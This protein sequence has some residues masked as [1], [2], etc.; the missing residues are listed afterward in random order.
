VHCGPAR[1]PQCMQRAPSS[2]HARRNPHPTKN[3]RDEP[4]EHDQRPRGVHALRRRRQQR[5]RDGARR[6]GGR[7]RGRVQ[8]VSAARVTPH[9]HRSPLCRSDSGVAPHSRPYRS[10]LCRSDSGVA[11]QRRSQVHHEGRA[12]ERAD[13]PLSGLPRGARLPH[14]HRIP[15]QRRPGGDH[16][17]HWRV[18][19]A[20][21]EQAHVLHEMRHAHVLEPVQGGSLRLL[22]AVHP[23]WGRRAAGQPHLPQRKGS[24][25]RAVAVRRS[26]QVWAGS[27]QRSMDRCLSDHCRGSARQRKLTRAFRVSSETVRGTALCVA[28][29]VRFNRREQQ[30]MQTLIAVDASVHPKRRRDTDHPSSSSASS[31]SSASPRPSN[32]RPRA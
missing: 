11:P 13:L 8:L 23:I 31:A 5:A 4:P 32:P 10:P 20:R 24:G 16:G 7:R 19:P 21:T 28:A 29:R 30:R 2:P 12:D 3:D 26:A 22:R 27:G 9:S 15:L 6:G 17:T 1:A 25:G 18:R 14:E